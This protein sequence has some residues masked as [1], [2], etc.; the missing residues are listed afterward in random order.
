MWFV[1]QEKIDFRICL[2]IWEANPDVYME[3][4]G[5]LQN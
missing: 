1:V 3:L 4:L 5:A 2:L